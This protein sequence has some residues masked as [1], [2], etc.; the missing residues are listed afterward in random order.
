MDDENSVHEHHEIS[1]ALIN[2]RS[3]S[4]ENLKSYQTTP[5]HLSSSNHQRHFSL[6]NSDAGNDSDTNSHCALIVPDETIRPNKP[7]AQKSLNSNNNYELHELQD[8]DRIK[9]TRNRNKI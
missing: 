9:M 4:S 3:E 8:L 7:R 5:A 6:L 2:R 1:A